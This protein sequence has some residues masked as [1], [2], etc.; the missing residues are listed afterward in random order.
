MIQKNPI[1]IIAVS[2]VV[3]AAIAIVIYTTKK[4]RE[5]YRDPIYLTQHELARLYD[6]ANGTIY[7]PDSNIMTGYPF[8]PHAY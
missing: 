7:G 1:I 4:F 5:N 2:V 8:Y 6:A 3:I